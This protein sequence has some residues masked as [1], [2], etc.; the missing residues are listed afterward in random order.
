MTFVKICGIT[1]VE[2]ALDAAALGA[3][4]IGFVFWPG[5][6][7]AIGPGDARSIV[8]ALPPLLTPVGVFVDQPEEEVSQIVSDLRLGAVQLHGKE[9][10]DYCQRLRRPIIKAF[11]VGASFDERLIDGYPPG[12]TVLL[13]AQ[14]DVAHG[15]T[16]R[17]IDW[18][19]AARIA[20]LRRVMLAGGL[21][22]DNVEAAI[23][24]VRPFA[25]DVSSGVE[26]S[27]GVKDRSKMRRLFDAVRRADG[28]R[29]TSEGS[30]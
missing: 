19:R 10:P 18:A 25:I 15:G 11:G 14:D 17:S 13:D 8:D 29:G 22:P 5:S 4:A 12:I 1:R 20:A 9:P 30:G 3:S 27:P 23:A 2:D 6:P 21:Q 26:T 24:R 7:R 16:G 28:G